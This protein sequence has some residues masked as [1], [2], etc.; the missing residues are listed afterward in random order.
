MENSVNKNMK[1]LRKLHRLT[2]EEMGKILDMKRSTYAHTESYGTFKP[3]HLAKAAEH[4]GITVDD[5]IYGTFIKPTNS[6]TPDHISPVKPENEKTIFPLNPQE[7]NLIE[8]FRK[9]DI[10]R[11]NEI[12]LNVSRG[13]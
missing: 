7:I 12:L 5:I 8:M 9:L 3:E 2:Q 13:N 1:A 4:F 10:D 11:R 6:D